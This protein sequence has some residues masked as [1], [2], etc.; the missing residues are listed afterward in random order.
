MRPHTSFALLLIGIVLAGDA[1]A[2]QRAAGDEQSQVATGSARGEVN[3]APA[4]TDAPPEQTPND[5]AQSQGPEGQ[6]SDA[7]AQTDEGAKLTSVPGS[8]ALGMSILGNQDAPTALVIVP[9][10]TSELGGSLG[11][12]P[13]LDDSRQPVDKDVFM[14]SLR[15]Y[16]IRSETKP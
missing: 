6:A 16:E 12:A 3:G 10:K 2:A 14:R 4:K 1:W 13:L 5:P 7:Q 8:K 15:Y 9:W 11:V